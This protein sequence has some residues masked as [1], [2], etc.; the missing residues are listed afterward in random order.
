MTDPKTPPL[1]DDTAL[2]TALDALPGW[3]RTD[4]G[5]GIERRYRF[6]GFNAAFAFMT[7]HGP[8]SPRRWTTTPNGP[9]SSTASRFA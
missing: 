3:S 1:A 5:Q 2:R 9:T 7:P 4:D 6:K 8:S